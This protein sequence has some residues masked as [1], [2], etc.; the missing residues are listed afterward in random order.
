MLTHTR[1]FSRPGVKRII[2]FMNIDET[3]SLKQ[4]SFVNKKQGA[5]PLCDRF[6]T[7]IKLIPR[8]IKKFLIINVCKEWNEEVSIL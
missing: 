4:Y 1:W 2:T 8:R 3:L 7:I 6:E 5:I